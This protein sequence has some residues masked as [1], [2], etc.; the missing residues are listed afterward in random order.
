MKNILFC[1]LIFYVI[2]PRVVC[3]ELLLNIRNDVSPGLT[4]S[5]RNYFIK[6]LDGILIC[7]SKLCV[8]YF[9]I[10]FLLF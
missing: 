1:L 7:Y 2:L 5:L 4:L 3:R 9:V 8:G 6:G 10:V